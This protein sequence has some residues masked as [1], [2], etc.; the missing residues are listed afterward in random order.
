[1]R[2]GPLSP[3]SRG[4]SPRVLIIYLSILI[5]Q[6]PSAALGSLPSSIW[7]RFWCRSL[8]IF[9]FR[10]RSIRKWHIC[11]RGD[12]ARDP[13]RTH[14]TPDT[15]K[16]FAKFTLNAWLTSRSGMLELS[17]LYCLWQR[18]DSALTIH[19]LNCQQVSLTV[20]YR[21]IVAISMSGRI[22]LSSPVGAVVCY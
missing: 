19:L 1:M 8:H 22:I 5:L 17:A 12:W 7:A 2:L 11:P 4:H 3:V 9:P 15:C 13:N 21:S 16:H 14:S 10:Q 20:R 6:L 18:R